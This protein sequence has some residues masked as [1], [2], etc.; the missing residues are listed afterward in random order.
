MERPGE[1]PQSD[2]QVGKAT[3]GNDDEVL[4]EILSLAEGESHRVFGRAVVLRHFQLPTCGQVNDIEKGIS[5]DICNES[6][7]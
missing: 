7:Q 1:A 5:L 2:Y 3:R 6:S 4:W